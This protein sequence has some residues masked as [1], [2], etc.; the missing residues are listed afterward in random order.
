MY[1]GWQLDFGRGLHCSFVSF[2]FLV[3]LHPIDH[4]VHVSPSPSVHVILLSIDTIKLT[5]LRLLNE[6]SGLVHYNL[7]THDHHNLNCVCVEHAIYS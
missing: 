2:C 4:N 5:Q 3:Y 7:N 6:L 1:Y